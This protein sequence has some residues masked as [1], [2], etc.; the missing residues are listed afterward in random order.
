MPRVAKRRQRCKGYCPATSKTA[1][2]LTRGEG[3]G[4]RCHCCNMQTR[5]V[6][7]GARRRLGKPRDALHAVRW[8]A[9]LMQCAAARR[10][11]RPL[12]LLASCAARRAGSTP[13]VPHD[14]SIVRAK[15]CS[16]PLAI[17]CQH[18]GGSKVQR[19]ERACVGVPVHAARAPRPHGGPWDAKAM[20]KHMHK[21][22]TMHHA[23][24][25][26]RRAAPARL[27]APCPIP[28]DPR[29]RSPQRIASPHLITVNGALDIARFARVDDGMERILF[30]GH[31]ALL[32][33]A[34]RT[35]EAARK[36]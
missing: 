14:A 9:G 4:W 13:G 8:A 10:Q 15:P 33:G 2:R 22:C 32:V 21:I 17:F 26:S 34:K 16:I 31:S 36:M 11:S 7:C 1:P 12:H 25:R 5:I 3:K 19:C 29:P 23:T 6:H 35:N 20:L 27:R 28:L 24:D 18:R 30:G